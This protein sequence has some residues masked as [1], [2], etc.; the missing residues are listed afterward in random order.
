MFG[1]KGHLGSL[2]TILHEKMIFQ[3]LKHDE[4]WRKK[5]REIEMGRAGGRG[6]NVMT[7]LK[8]VLLTNW[9]VSAVFR[10]F[11]LQ[12]HLSACLSVSCSIVVLSFNAGPSVVSGQPK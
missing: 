5:L 7:L 2:L 3:C 9:W 10:D 11:S 4:Q 6:D 1:I 8:I 12:V